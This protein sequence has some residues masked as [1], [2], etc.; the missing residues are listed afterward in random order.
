MDAAEEM[1]R[2]F[3]AK[4]NAEAHARATTLDWS[5]ISPKLVLNPNVTNFYEMTI[6]DFTM[7]NY[8]PIKPQLKLELGI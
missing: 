1:L 4:M 2:R 8:N 3:E 5:P 6:D 7:E